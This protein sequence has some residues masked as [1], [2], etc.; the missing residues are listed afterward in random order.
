MTLQRQD[1]L[2]EMKEYLIRLESHIR[3]DIMLRHQN[4][5]IEL[6]GF[7]RD[8]LNQTFGWYLGNANTKLG[9]NQD[10]FDLFDDVSEILVLLVASSM[11]APPI[12]VSSRSRQNSIFLSRSNAYR[13][14]IPVD[15]E[16]DSTAIK[17][18]LPELFNLK[19]R[20]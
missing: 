15:I 17:S 18:H 20:S 2:T 10:S 8:L 9:P 6:E 12:S 1:H 3:A 7:F 4:S 13:R 16:S 11:R 14:K 19:R 5:H